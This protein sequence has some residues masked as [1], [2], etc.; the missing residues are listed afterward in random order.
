MDVHS[1]P[2][3]FKVG[4]HFGAFIVVSDAADFSLAGMYCPGKLVDTVSGLDKVSVGDGSAS[5][6]RQDEAICDGAHGVSEVVILHAE[7]G[8]SR[9]R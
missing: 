8:L 5:S 7:D 9:A 1:P 4:W 2:V 3:A 6:Y